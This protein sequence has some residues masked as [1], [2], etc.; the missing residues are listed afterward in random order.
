LNTSQ[1]QFSEHASERLLYKCGK[2]KLGNMFK[3]VGF[4]LTN[5]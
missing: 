4:L 2:F 5:E 3:S 1:W